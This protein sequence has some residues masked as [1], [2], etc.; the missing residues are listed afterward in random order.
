VMAFEARG[1]GAA[2]YEK[3]LAYIKSLLGVKK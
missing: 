2:A 1:W 3:G